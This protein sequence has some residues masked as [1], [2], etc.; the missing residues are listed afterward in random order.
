[1]VEAEPEKAWD[2]E[3]VDGKSKDIRVRGAHHYAGRR[4]VTRSEPKV[5][6]LRRWQGRSGDWDIWEAI[7]P[8]LSGL[9]SGEDN[10]VVPVPYGG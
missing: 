10:T 4:N 5:D 3:W 1:M 6:R 2:S 9:I 8:I 7:V